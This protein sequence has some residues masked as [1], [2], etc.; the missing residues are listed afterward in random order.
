MADPYRSVTPG[1]PV[2]I[3]ARA[4]N[5]LMAGVRNPPPTIGGENRAPT[6][7]YTWVYAKNVTGQAVSRGLPMAI[8]GL[9]Q[10]PVAGAWYD[11][12][13]QIRGDDA[14]PLASATNEQFFQAPV[15]LADYPTQSLPHARFGVTIEGIG[16]GMVGRLAVGGVVQASI[17]Y[18]RAERPFVDVFPKEAFPNPGNSLT[19]VARTSGRGAVLAVSDNIEKGYGV[20]AGNADNPRYALVQLGV[21]RVPV[22]GTVNVAWSTGATATVTNTTGSTWTAKNYGPPIAASGTVGCII[23]W[24]GAEWVLTYAFDKQFARAVHTH[25]ADDIVSGQL[26]RDRMPTGVVYR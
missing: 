1:E 9:A 16:K 4:W 18:Y 23:E 7:C 5:T 25:S 6:P 11:E 17:S 22:R 8:T 14:F 12:K 13:G 19:L 21:N 26:S 24:V 3:H 2:R 15:V 10:M 20:N